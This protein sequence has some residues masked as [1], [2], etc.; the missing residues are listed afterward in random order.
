MAIDNEDE[1]DDEVK[2]NCLISYSSSALVF[3]WG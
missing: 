3:L 1:D 2:E